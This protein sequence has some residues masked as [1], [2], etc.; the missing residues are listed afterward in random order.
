MKKSNKKSM[1]Y[2]LQ[3]FELFPICCI[4]VQ[5]QLKLLK[6][7]RWGA[8]V[9]NLITTAM[10]VGGGGGEF[11]QENLFLCHPCC[12]YRHIYMNIAYLMRTSLS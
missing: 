7:A 5:N 10:S 8:I 4:F 11:F 12:I 9:F 6:I 1:K 2:F 3:F